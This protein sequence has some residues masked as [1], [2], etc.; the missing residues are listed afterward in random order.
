MTL[1]AAAGAGQEQG[2]TQTSSTR[3][4]PRLVGLGAT[5]ALLRAAGALSRR[6]PGQGPAQCSRQEGSGQLQKKLSGCTDRHKRPA[7]PDKKSGAAVHVDFL[8]H[9]LGGPAALLEAEI[10][11]AVEA[12]NEKPIVEQQGCSSPR[13]C[14]ATTAASSRQAS[15]QGTVDLNETSCSQKREQFCMHS[16]LDDSD[17]SDGDDDS[18]DECQDL[19]DMFDFDPE[20]LAG[21][22]QKGAS[23]DDL[24]EHLQGEYALALEQR[25]VG[26]KKEGEEAVRE[27]QH[28]KC[29]IEM[30]ELP[31]LMTPDEVSPIVTPKGASAKNKDLDDRCSPEAVGAALEL[32]GSRTQERARRSLAIQQRPSAAARQ[33]TAALAIR[34]VGRRSLASARAEGLD[35]GEQKALE[36]AVDA[37]AR[38]LSQRHRRSVTKAVEVLEELADAG[39]TRLERWPEAEVDAKVDLIQ[40][41]M[42]RAYR[43]HR[44]SIEDAVQQV[45]SGNVEESSAS[46]HH[47]SQGRIYDAV[48]VAYQ[49]EQ[50]HNT[51][52]GTGEQ[53]YDQHWQYFQHESLNDF[54]EKSA[55]WTQQE[56]GQWHEQWHHSSWPQDGQSAW[57]EQNLNAQST[58]G[59]A[60]SV[61]GETAWYG[62]Q[63][64]RDR[65]KNQLGRNA[66]P[67]AA[68]HGNWRYGNG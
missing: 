4:R 44:Q 18:S 54:Q 38:R 15:V 12:E 68:Q 31:S 32:V 7:P 21:L 42:E 67:V 3:P 20:K 48:A 63:S 46:M 60:Q 30:G 40:D 59:S 22:M 43:C 41:A 24:T 13:R 29:G 64:T 61:L 6:A 66:Q 9:C 37:A 62:Q 8:E 57:S 10:D 25:L 49:Q 19:E 58:W 56:T 1:K 23:D 34:A 36:G 28:E 39:E 52:Y 11:R 55:W 14:S 5:G 45:V 50:W 33:S 53:W 51:E 17:V 26:V 35:I 47:V 27:E 65:T 2:S 16:A